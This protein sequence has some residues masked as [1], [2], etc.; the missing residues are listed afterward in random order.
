MFVD[1]PFFS[2]HFFPRVAFPKNRDKLF[3]LTR[4][5][6]DFSPSGKLLSNFMVQSDIFSTPKLSNCQIVEL[7]CHF[8]LLIYSHR[9][10][11][12]SS[13]RPL[14]VFPFEYAAHRSVVFQSDRGICAFFG[15]GH[16]FLP[17]SRSSGAFS[18]H[19]PFAPS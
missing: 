8:A 7:P 10:L 15:M 9:L 14:P 19:H 4:G 5:Y 12:F 17:I 11:I 1:A 13:S 2:C 18:P 16:Y 3:L 6:S